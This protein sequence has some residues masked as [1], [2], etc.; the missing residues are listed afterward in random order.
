MA[1][2]LRVLLV[3]DSPD[4]AE[5]VEREL[6]LGGYDPRLERV[7][8]AEGLQRKLI[9]EE[10]DLIIA[11]HIMPHFD[12]LRAIQLARAHAPQ[13]PIILI[14]GKIGVEVAVQALK[15]GAANYIMKDRLKLLAAAVGHELESARLARQ[16]RA[17]E[18]QN[19][20]LSQALR[21]SPVS[22]LITDDTGIIQ[23]AN[24]H[25][26]NLTGY[27]PEELAGQSPRIFKSGET[28][29]ETYD[30]LW[31]T[32][33]EKK[34]WYGTLRNRKKNGEL[35]WEQASIAPVVDEAGTVSNFVA[36]KEDISQR[37]QREDE[38]K[39]KNDELESFTYTVSHDLRSPLVTFKTFLGYLREDL[40]KD[41]REVITRDMA[42]MEDAANKMERL[43]NGLLSLSRVGR[44]VNAPTE[45]GYQKL[46]EEALSI[47]A[48]QLA[49]REVSVTVMPADLRLWGDG[50]RLLEIWQNLLENAI[51][52]M[53]K[54]PAPQI[55]VG[56]EKHGSDTLFFVRDNGM[57]IEQK[58]VERIFGLFEKLDA[59]SDG[60]G[61]GL[62]LVKKIVL[63]YGGRI[64]VESD[65][66]GTGSCFKFTLPGAIRPG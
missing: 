17:L 40:E 28:A 46:V 10:W 26:T 58:Y 11:D 20:L 13:T 32:L 42:F 12:G 63:V 57:G 8:T 5:L 35:F 60:I 36:V 66:P 22:I 23:Y 9:E 50:L 52:Y 14:S 49:R 48:G 56:T 39:S 31:S 61:I 4:D 59:S 33:R 21:Q 64:W 43:L 19:Q 37:I 51:K 2:R 29:P 65:G 25:V 15:A 44:I 27:Q 34:T 41:D 53:G 45:L 62:A 38:L 24:P 3:E 30:N 55:W 1:I 18:Q 54:Q 16:N 47:M 6:R 7:E